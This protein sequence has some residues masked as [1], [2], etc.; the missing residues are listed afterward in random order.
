MINYSV[1]ITIDRPAADV[2]PYLADVTQ[3]PAW[4]GGTYAAPISEGSMRVGYRY[5]QSTDEGDWEFEIT[6]FEAG[7]LFSARTI[8]GPVDWTGTFEVLPNEPQDSRVVS[9]GSIRLLGIR[10][11]LEPFAGGEVRKS[12]LG[13]LVRLKALVEG[14]AVQ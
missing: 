12:E 4:M 9:R 7:R 13:E 2:F 3:H 11:L 8:T 14:D 10:R 1:D 6:E 5:R